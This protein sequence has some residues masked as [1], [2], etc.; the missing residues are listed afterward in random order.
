[1]GGETELAK[2]GEGEEGENAVKQLGRH[3][4][5]VAPGGQTRRQRPWTTVQICSLAI[6][7]V[8]ILCWCYLK[9]KLA[10]NK[11]VRVPLV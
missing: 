1:M 2:V 4:K 10:T 5:Q 6:E 9:L 8:N 7:R 11:Y 3:F